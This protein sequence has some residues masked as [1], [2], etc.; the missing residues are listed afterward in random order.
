MDRISIT[1]L[2]HFHLRGKGNA[3]MDAESFDTLTEALLRAVTLANSGEI[4][5]VEEVSGRCPV[6]TPKTPSVN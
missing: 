3:S 2:T 1:T 6:C 5:S 4:V